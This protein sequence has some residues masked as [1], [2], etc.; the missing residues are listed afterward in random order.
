MP[1]SFSLRVAVVIAAVTLLTSSAA[2]TSPSEPF[3]F[4]VSFAN[5]PDG[6]QFQLPQ[7]LQLFND[8]HIVKH[9]NGDTG[10]N[11]SKYVM[12]IVSHDCKS[13]HCLQFVY[14]KGSRGTFLEL[15]GY[16]SSGFVLVMSQADILNVEFDWLA[17]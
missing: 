16:G 7:Q 15:P 8:P 5:L 4:R 12:S 11:V 17:T 14:P 1:L 9:I 13:A 6:S 2:E 10:P 3:D